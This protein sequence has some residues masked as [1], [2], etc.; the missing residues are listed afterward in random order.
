MTVSSIA[1]DGLPCPSGEE[2]HIL[3]ETIW[4]PFTEHL[5]RPVVDDID[6]ELYGQ[7]LEWETA[8]QQL[9]PALLRNLDPNVRHTQQLSLTLAGAADCANSGRVLRPRRTSAAIPMAS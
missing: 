1:P 5:T 2:G 4:A 3:L 7:G 8:A 9:R 6:R